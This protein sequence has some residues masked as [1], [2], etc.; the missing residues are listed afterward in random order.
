MLLL[1]Q[2]KRQDNISLNSS[3]DFYSSSL[4]PKSLQTVPS[5][6]NTIGLFVTLMSHT[7]LDLRQGTSICLSFR[8]L[9]FLLSGPLER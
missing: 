4:F 6:A 1:N 2:W 9:L 5:K 7:F 8:F 3:S